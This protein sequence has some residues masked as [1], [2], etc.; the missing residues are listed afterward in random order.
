MMRRRRR[1]GGGG[2][3]RR[4]RGRRRRARRTWTKRSNGSVPF[5]DMCLTAPCLSTA[6][7]YLDAEDWCA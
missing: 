5:H 3:Q 7:V 4:R 1:A 6:R 2:E